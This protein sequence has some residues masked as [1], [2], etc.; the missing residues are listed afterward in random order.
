M[1][2]ILHGPLDDVDI[3]IEPPARYACPAS[4]VLKL[5]KAICRLHAP[6]KFKQEVVAWFRAN[7]YQPVNDSGT[8]WIKR[9]QEK[10]NQEG[11]IV[12]HALYADDFLHFT[13]NPMLYQS[14]REDFQKLFDVQ[15]GSVGI[16]GTR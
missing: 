11:S 9:V 8:I 5:H 2:A 16:W 10:R 13:D 14:F 15:S 12:F 6:V 1:Q 4:Y 3:Y 7:R